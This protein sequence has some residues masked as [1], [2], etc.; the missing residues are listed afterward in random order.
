MRAI[1]IDDKDA[2][3]LVEGLRLESMRKDHPNYEN[4]GNPLTMEQMH[5]IFHSRVV[6]WLQEQGADVTKP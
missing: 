6:R 5:R 2:K 1:I 4:P 3:A